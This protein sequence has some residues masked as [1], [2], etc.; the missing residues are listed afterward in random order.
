[1]NT[2]PQSH[3]H[4]AKRET[5]FEVLSCLRAYQPRTLPAGLLV[6]SAVLIPVLAGDP[7]RLIYTRRSDSLAHHRGQV[8][9][10]GGRLEPGETEQDAALREAQEEIGIRAADVT[11]LG[12]VD[13]VV[14]PRGFHIACFVGWVDCW[15]PRINKEEVAEVIP[16]PLQDLFDRRL[17]ETRPWKENPAISVH[18]F[19][20]GSTVV[21]GV[22]GDISYRLRIAI[23]SV[24]RTTL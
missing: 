20:F 14:S 18:Y 1:M 8:S 3:L 7:A 21:W 10:P 4:E 22:T 6:P 2:D 9:F 16:V 11:I 15:T 24:M 23:E 12:R 17:H 19:Q 5:C 13:D